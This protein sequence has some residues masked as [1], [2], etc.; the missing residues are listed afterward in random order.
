MFTKKRWKFR[1]S[2]KKNKV[3]SLDIPMEKIKNFNIILYRS[4]IWVDPYYWSSRYHSKWTCDILDRALSVW[5]FAT[6]SMQ[7]AIDI[8]D[9]EKK[10]LKMP[11]GFGLD[12][13][14]SY[15]EY[16][17]IW[18]PETGI[19]EKIP[20]NITFIDKRKDYVKPIHVNFEM[21]TDMRDNYQRDA[22]NFLLNTESHNK[23][24]SLGT[25]YGKTFCAIYCICKKQVPA[26]II[27]AN[28]SKQWIERIKEYTKISDDKI[29]EVR[30]MKSIEK[31]L[32]GEPNKDI[33][34]F[35]SSTT[36]L[37]MYVNQGGK[38]DDLFQK[39]GVGIKVF[40]EA[41]TFYSQNAK[42]DVNSNVE[43][44]YYLTATPQRSNSEERKIFDKI[45]KHI[46]IHGMHTHYINK[47]YIIRVVNYNSYPKSNDV[48]ACLRT[49]NKFFSPVAYS[50]YIFGNN[51]KSLFYMG[52]IKYFVDQL[53]KEEDMKIIIILPLLEHISIIQNFLSSFNNVRYRVSQYTSAIDIDKRES[54]LESDVIL[55]TLNSLKEGRDVKGLRAIFCLT[56][57]SSTLIA[58][59]LLGRLRPIEGKN[60]YYY[61][62]A[63]VGFP[64][65]KK[66]R[67]SRKN[68]FLM[69][70]QNVQLKNITQEEVF[71]YMKGQI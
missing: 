55:S 45:F 35:V 57:F 15:L 23:L 14:L 26:I 66:Q 1:T 13:A 54:Q 59:Q 69:R 5:N 71:E 37:N 9:F 60:T 36:T 11:I 4:S 62:F 38:L 65:M 16:H 24:L 29:I 58:Q 21:K 31:I 28:L 40:D 67:D 2:F 48:L 17:Y 64:K 39:M 8:Y 61:D 43:E 46:P 41:H 33:P 50:Q 34:F 70:K 52:M 10:I 12:E 22:I 7:R 44:T 68:E 3:K 63:D 32:N 19:K 53:M 42:L 49:S 30:G 51:E 56:S 20:N 27:S 25:G 18:N 47:H 6:R